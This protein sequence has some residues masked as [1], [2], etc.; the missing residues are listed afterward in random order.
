MLLDKD[1]DISGQELIKVSDVM[2]E[3]CVI[4]HNQGKIC[5]IFDKEKP[6]YLLVQDILRSL[7]EEL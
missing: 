4:G 5:S 3:Y 7:G 1:T 6:G 2:T